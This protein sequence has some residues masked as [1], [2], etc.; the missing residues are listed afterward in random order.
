MDRDELRRRLKEGP[1]L[2]DGGTGT[3]LIAAGVRP[4]ACLEELNL[5]APDMVAAVHRAFVDAGSRLVET[6][7]FGANRYKLVR[8]GLGARV[9]EICEAGAA[10]ARGSGAEIVAGSAG[11]LGV[12]LA[13]YG[14]VQPAEARGAFAEQLQAL[15]DGGVDLFLVETHSDLAEAEQAVAAAREVAPEVPL[16]VTLT[17]TRDDRTVLG[18]TAE[19]VAAR[20]AEL[21]V[22]ALGANCSEGPAQVLRLLT[23]MRPHAGDVPLVAQPNAGGPQRMAGRVVFPATASYFAEHVEA[24]AEA[25]AAII[26]GCCGTEPQHIASAARALA[27]PR[28]VPPVQVV[29]AD[30]EQPLE[31]SAPQAPTALARTLAGGSFAV[32]VEMDPP[33]GFSAAR[34]VAGA[35]TL[36]EAGADTINVADSPMAR[37]RMSPWAAAHLIQQEAGIETVL[38]FP[39]RGRNLLRIQGDLLAAY[40]LG[41]RNIFACMGD[42]TSIGDVP[43][44]GD[45]ADVTPSG[46]IALIKQSFNLGVDRAGASIGAPTS[47]FVGCAANVNARDI[48]REIRVLHRKVAAGADFALSQAAFEP[49]RV[50]RFL[51]AYGERHGALPIP[52]LVGVLPLVT[53]RHAEFLHNEVPG[54]DIPEALR[55][56]MARAADPRAEGLSIAGELCAA[57]KQR[58]AGI[59]LIPP[60][61]RYDL[62][63]EIVERIRA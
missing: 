18:E 26:G 60:F 31:T 34:L 14:R 48:E 43:E 17:F 37:M 49:E 50:D 9:R 59:Y 47:F 35:E 21:G 5:V 56:R 38:H 42:P 63:A 45:R 7:T 32:T 23:A 58:A 54:I 41:I 15:A 57:L 10:L 52:L 4:D 3:S 39:T 8:F 13:P 29:S 61:S 11:P 30:P 16:I 53:S 24:F 25:G 40:A 22:D 46:L 2:A 12:R 1:L 28:L 33:R 20:L 27:Q 6:N 62:A 19:V 36:R 55:D 51:A 44:A